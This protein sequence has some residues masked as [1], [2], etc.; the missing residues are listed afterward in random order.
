MKKLLLLF[1]LF[2]STLLT[3]AQDNLIVLNNPNGDD[4]LQGRINLKVKPEYRTYFE[5][6]KNTLPG[7]DALE[8]TG[9]RKK[10]P[11]RKALVNQYHANGKMLPDLSL[12]YELDYTATQDVFKTAEQLLSSQLFD[13]AEPHY[14]SY[15]LYTPN[16]PRVAQ[17]NPYHLNTMQLYAAWDVNQGDSN[18]VIGYTDT[19]FDTVSYTHLTLPTNREV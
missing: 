19:S 18:I 10:F 7:F 11:Q 6:L 15:P 8:I 13:Y 17:Y 14:V 2:I 5:N 1:T 3:H 9:L 4:Y 12:I 16:D